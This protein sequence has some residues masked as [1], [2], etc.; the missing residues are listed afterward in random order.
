MLNKIGKNDMIEFVTE[1]CH[2]IEGFNKSNFINETVALKRQIRTGEDQECV[3]HNALLNRWEKSLENDNPD[4][5]VYGELAI[6]QD[7]WSCWAIY[8]RTYLRNLHTRLCMGKP[9]I[10]ALGEVKT[11]LDIGNGIGYST[12]ALKQIFPEAL[13]YGNN[14]KKTFQWNICSKVA[15][16]YNFKMTSR[17]RTDRNVDLLFASEYFE[18][19][20]RPIEHLES[21]L[22]KVRPRNILIANSFGTQAI[23]HFKVYKHEEL[24]LSPASVNRVFRNLLKDFNYKKIPTSCWNNRPQ[25]WQRKN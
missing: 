25:F 13:V 17:L 12:A 19:H 24:R 18:H 16:K 23:G 1:F 3:N 14:I 20:E 4:Y 2:D 9:F 22:K 21:V 15:K 5:G 10:E 7:I 11:I 6:L 8:S